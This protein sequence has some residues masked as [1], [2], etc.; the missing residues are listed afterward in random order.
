MS[1]L[2]VSRVMLPRFWKL[3]HLSKVM[4]P[5]TCCIN[6]TMLIT[7]GA[8]IWE[9]WQSNSLHQI[10]Q[11]LGV[12]HG[13]LQGLPSDIL[14]GQIIGEKPTPGETFG[15]RGHGVILA[16]EGLTPNCQDQEGGTDFLG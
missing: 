3:S 16:W 14:I 12:S 9:G 6:S 15:G 13:Q 11:C 4:C 1:Q 2:T 5:L 8:I 7:K 10:L